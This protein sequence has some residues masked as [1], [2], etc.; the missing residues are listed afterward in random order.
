MSQLHSRWLLP[1]LLFAGLSSTLYAVDGV[2]LIDQNHAIAGGVTPGD[3]PGF[4]VTISQPGSYRLSG[5][6]TVPTVSTA[7]IVITADHVTIDLNGFSISGTVVCFQ[8][9]A[10]C[11]PVSDS[12]GIL[13]LSQF[14]KV[15]NGN[16]YGMGYG[17]LLNGAGSYV[18][19]VL[20]DT[21]FWMGIY[22]KSGVVVNNI[23]TR[24]G[25]VGILADGSAT[26]SGNNAIG[27]GQYGYSLTCP[28]VMIGNSASL[29]GA[30]VQANGPGCTF[31][32]NAP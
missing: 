18:E 21:C 1:A 11:E 27:N 15:V 22:I 5:N 4:P 25:T 13:S 23:V 19:K 12:A 17:L 28:T 3:A 32:G 16:V 7:G 30:N 8:T 6:L 29:N 14:T 31:T 26:I 20:V 24:N 10:L 9:P 2:I